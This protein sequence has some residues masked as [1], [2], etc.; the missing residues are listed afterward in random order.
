MKGKMLCAAV[1]IIRRVRSLMTRMERALLVYEWKLFRS[2]QQAG[3][4]GS[5]DAG[6]EGSQR[7]VAERTGESSISPR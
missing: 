3:M 7:P 5:G 1:S 6:G 4:S 2:A